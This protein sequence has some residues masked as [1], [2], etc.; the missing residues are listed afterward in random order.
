[1]MGAVFVPNHGRLPNPLEPLASAGGINDSSRLGPFARKGL[2]SVA[3]VDALLND[4]NRVPK[5]DTGGRDDSTPP[6]LILISKHQN[7]IHESW[8]TEYTL[9]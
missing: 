4:P 9:I 7:S 8:H 1:M 2:V 3:F 5:R 6:H